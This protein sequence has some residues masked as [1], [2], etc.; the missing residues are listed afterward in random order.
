MTTY[1]MGTVTFVVSE[2]HADDFIN[3][4]QA[5]QIMINLVDY[6]TYQLSQMEKDN[7]VKVTGFKWTRGCITIIIP[8]GVVATA[9]GGLATF[10]LLKDYK[11]VREGV[12][13]ILED[14]KNIS[15]WVKR[16]VFRKKIISIPDNK[17]T[18][19]DKV[20]T[21]EQTF[22]VM[23][24]KTK[25]QLRGIPE[26]QRKYWSAGQD[27]I[28]ADE[29]GDYCRYTLSLKREDIQHPGDFKTPHKPVKKTPVRRRKV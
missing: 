29:K 3:D 15:I 20:K 21:D 26:E 27:V 14:L 6:F 7:A 16:K 8:L 11:D 5:E 24:E 12:F 17:G 9:G 19:N 28:I 1:P 2:Y 22:E 25:E 10:K 18:E 23:F 4:L 13:K